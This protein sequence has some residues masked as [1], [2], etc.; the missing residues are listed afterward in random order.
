MIGTT[1]L[2]DLK[3]ECVVGVHDHERVTRQT[4][5]LDIGLDYDFSAAAR[6]DALAHAVDY[7]MVAEAVSELVQRRK[8]QLIET[9]AEEIAQLLLERLSLVNAA[10]IEIRK[11]AA[12][13]AAA[14]A[15][16]SIERRRA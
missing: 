13:K 9:M 11:P 5:A 7:A 10:R 6:T 1:G 16:V 3:I 2:K 4:V 15:F 8:Y 14:A 12:V